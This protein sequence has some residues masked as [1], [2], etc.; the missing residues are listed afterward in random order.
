MSMEMPPPHAPAAASGVPPVATAMPAPPSAPPVIPPCPPMPSA[1]APHFAPPSL[2]DDMVNDKK[3][4]DV[5]PADG[6]TAGG[7]H[8]NS[9]C[10]W[11][12]KELSFFFT[13]SCPCLTFS[14]KAVCFSTTS[15]SPSSRSP[16]HIASNFSSCI[17]G[18]SR[19]LKS[20]W[21]SAR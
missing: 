13:T 17:C 11:R 7:I 8:R 1:E 18:C 4:L 9:F 3:R 5:M 12:R 20:V 21:I 6:F 10:W 19:T 14:A 2:P 16:T 15:V